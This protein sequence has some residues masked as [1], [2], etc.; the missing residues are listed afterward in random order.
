M[1][2][3]CA[4]CGV[5]LTPDNDSAEHLITNSIGG[6]KKVK[7]VYCVPCNTSTGTLWDAELARQFQFLALQLGI[8][9]DRGTASSGTFATV[10]GVPIRLHPDGTL[11]F[12]PAKPVV[13]KEGNAVRIASRVRNRAEAERM[14]RGFQR[15][16]PKLDVEAA[17]QT[18]AEETSYLSEP[19]IEVTAF[20][21]PLA[22]RSAVKSAL[23]LAVSAG[24]EPQ[25]CNLALAYLKNE[26]GEPS[27][28][29]YSRRDLVT[30]RPQGRVFHCVAIEGDPASGRLIGY[31]EFFGVYR[32]VIV[33]SDCYTEPQV[34]AAYTI[35][36]TTGA[37]MNLEVNLTFT[38][39]ELRLAVSKADDVTSAQVQAM[40]E[41]MAIAQQLS[42]KRE[43]V[44]VARHA[45]QAT[46][47]KLDLKPGQDMTPDIAL[48]MSREMTAQLMP[49]LLHRM[50]LQRRPR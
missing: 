4:L 29:F 21:G 42:I 10:S 13:T 18:V 40:N 1:N 27:F 28:G 22:G 20:G 14:L 7:G 5:E 32:M 38:E 33:L 24:V 23:T 25:S 45:Y 46:L 19:V 35:D 44:R 34:K 31:V 3:Q 9:R 48:A 15:T 50:S 41:V 37:E 26:E 8:V 11:S 12:P 17:M 16:Y 47:S 43:E 2:S 6:K 49:F 30:N 39:D 36:P